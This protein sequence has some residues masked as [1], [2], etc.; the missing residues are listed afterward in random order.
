MLTGKRRII[1]NRYSKDTNVLEEV[2]Q[3]ETARN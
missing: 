1:D 2:S 3:G